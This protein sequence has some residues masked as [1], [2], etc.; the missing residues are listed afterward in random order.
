MFMYVYV[1]EEQRYSVF[2]ENYM[3][4]ITTFLSLHRIFPAIATNFDFFSFDLAATFD[5]SIYYIGFRY[6]NPSDTQYALYYN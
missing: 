3:L 2:Y 1:G 5:A 6:G 4:P